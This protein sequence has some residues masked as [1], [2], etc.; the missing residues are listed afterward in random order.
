MNSDSNGGEGLKYTLHSMRSK[1]NVGRQ[2]PVYCARVKM[3]ETFGDDDL[4]RELA[5]AVHQDEAFIRYIER[6]RT[7]V[8][9]NALKSGRRV[10]IAGVANVATIRGPFET[11][12]GE[13]DP[14]RNSLVVSSFTYGTRKKCLEEIVPKNLAERARPQIGDIREDGQPHLEVIVTGRTV[15]ITG[16]DMLVDASAA[17]EGVK[18]LDRTTGESVAVAAIESSALNNIICSFESLPPPGRYIL[19][20]LTRAGLP[21]EHKVARASREVTV[22]GSR[23]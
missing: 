22:K 3:G 19:E 5:A 12:D 13:F 9:E 14:E 1:L 20:I 8:I 17:D 21:R 4:V 15:V 11:I 6:E 18:L 16:R 10:Y 7:Q 2:K 23:G